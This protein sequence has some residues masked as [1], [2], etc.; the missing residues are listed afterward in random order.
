MDRDVELLLEDVERAIGDEE[1]DVH[2]RKF[3]EVLRDDVG[4]EDLRE[5]HG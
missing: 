2:L 5:Q 4:Q 1:L 3:R